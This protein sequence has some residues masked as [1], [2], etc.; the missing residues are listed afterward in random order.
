MTFCIDNC[1]GPRSPGEP[2][3]TV[4]ALAVGAAVVVIGVSIAFWCFVAF[5]RA[6]AATVA[7]VVQLGAAYAL[8]R[9][10]LGQ[11]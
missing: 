1:D 10:W 5:D 3:D 2:S 7:L 6:V 4:I 8:L 11:S 9:F